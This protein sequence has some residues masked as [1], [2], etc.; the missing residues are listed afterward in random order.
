M[1]KKSHK[2][3]TCIIKAII[4]V[5]TIVSLHFQSAFGNIVSIKKVKTI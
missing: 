1:Q 3:D 5:V 4:H 2:K